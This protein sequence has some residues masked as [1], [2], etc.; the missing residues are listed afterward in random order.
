GPWRRNSV[1][2]HPRRPQHDLAGEACPRG[3][4]MSGAT[5]AP[6]SRLSEWWRRA[7]N[8]AFWMPV[9]DGFAVLTAASL[10]W[11]TAVVTIFTACWR[12]SSARVADLP[13]WFRSL[14]QPICA[15]PLALL[16]LAAIGTLWSEA[17]WDTRLYAVSPAIKLLYLPALFHYFARSTRGMW[18]FVAFL[19]SCTLL[20]AASWLVLLDPS[21]AMKQ[22]PFERGIFVKN[23]IDQ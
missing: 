20:M 1:G 5:A 16:A 19:I 23:Y 21:L 7:C 4:G 17:S 3:T 15:L 12:G 2:R 9:A 22:D 8:P 13:A 14:K 10:P 18:V 11:A 6:A